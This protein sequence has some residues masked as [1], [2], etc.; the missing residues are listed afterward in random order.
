MFNHGYTEEDDWNI[1]IDECSSL[2]AKW[3]HLSGLLGLRPSLIAS[4]RGN[5]PY[6]NTGCWND[7]LLQWI[8]QQYNT[9]KF[10][11]PSWKNLLKAVSK[12]DNSLSQKLSVKHS[13]TKSCLSPFESQICSNEVIKGLVHNYY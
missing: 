10:G 13:K 3:E 1:V 11:K 5:H 4:I 7:A 8:T 2:A 6:D 9:I 12:V